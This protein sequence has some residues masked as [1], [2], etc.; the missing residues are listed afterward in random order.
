MFDGKIN[1]MDISEWVKD[2]NNFFKWKAMSCECQVKYLI[3]LSNM[4]MRCMI[5]T[6][7]NEY[8]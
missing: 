3:Y 6:P 7:K 8:D 2:K 1:P 5:V 4:G